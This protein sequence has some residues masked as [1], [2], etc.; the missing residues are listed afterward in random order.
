MRAR[1]IPT[2]T[3]IKM[4]STSCQILMVRRGQEVVIPHSLQKQVVKISHEGHQGIV[5]T[6][7]FLRSR[8][9]FPGIDKLVERKSRVAFHAKPPHL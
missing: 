8:V 3:V 7:Q 5:L 1:K 2:P 9:W 4:F 6:K